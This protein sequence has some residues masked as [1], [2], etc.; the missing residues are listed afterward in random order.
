MPGITEE[1]NRILDDLD[2]RKEI[3]DIQ[4]R[5][6]QALVKKV[7]DGEPQNPQALYLKGR[8]LIRLT[9]ALD[10]PKIR[11][12]ILNLANEIAVLGHS[13]AYYY[14]QFS[15]LNELQLND[16]DIYEEKKNACMEILKR[17]KNPSMLIHHIAAERFLGSVSPPPPPPPPVYTPPV[18]QP[19]QPAT[20]PV[21]PPTPARPIPQ[22]L[23]PEGPVTRRPLAAFTADNV[24]GAPPLVVRFRDQSSGNP[25]EWSWE[26]GDGSTSSEANPSHTYTE[27]GQYTVTLTIS[28]RSGR[29]V[30][31][32]NGLILATRPMA[33]GPDPDMVYQNAIAGMV[34]EYPE[35]RDLILTMPDNRIQL[36]GYV[37]DAFGG[38]TPTEYHIL[39][40]CIDEE[41][42]SVILKNSKEKNKMN[43]FVETKKGVLKN[44]GSNPVFVDWACEVWKKALANGV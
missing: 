34:K 13:A 31:S 40:Q 27:A 42:P 43:A 17:P 1:L 28:G 22:P 11:T 16:T 21:S 15:L 38:E 5:R 20:P 4:L 25:N 10:R 3:S 36:K 26:F 37:C 12:E 41:I 8:L 9:K 32:K 33:D 7:L 24:S 29:D 30:V 6:Y 23:R 44:K 14:R 19:R 39:L 18:P 2:N 35:I